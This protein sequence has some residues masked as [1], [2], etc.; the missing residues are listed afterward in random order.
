MATGGYSSNSDD[1]TSE[2]SSTEL[3]DL[4][5]DISDEENKLSEDIK[6]LSLERQRFLERLASK[7][8]KRHATLLGILENCPSSHRVI[9]EFYHVTN[10]TAKEK[11]QKQGKLVATVSHQPTNRTASPIDKLEIKGVHFRLNLHKNDDCLPT[12]SPFGTERVRIPISYFS[13]YEL[14]FNHC[15]RCNPRTSGGHEVYFVSLVLVKPSDDDYDDIKKVLKKLDPKEN[16]FV[17]FDH[18]NGTYGYY[19]YYKLNELQ[20]GDQRCRAFNVY[21]EIAVI[22]DVLFPVW[23]SVTKR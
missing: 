15:N 12:D 23:D 1:D 14:F 19:D 18:K 11:I 7:V 16:D 21:Y 20:P 10:A 17:Y 13:E 22:D 3:S 4:H 5:E 6:R 9:R 2:E 8:N